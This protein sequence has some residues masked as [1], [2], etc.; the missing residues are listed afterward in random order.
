MQNS[1]T[2]EPR[3]HVEKRRDTFCGMNVSKRFGAPHK[4]ETDDIARM[5]A[6]NLRLIRKR[7]KKEARRR[8]FA[9]L[10]GLPEDLPVR[11]GRKR[12]GGRPSRKSMLKAEK[13]CGARSKEVKSFQRR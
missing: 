12:K 6:N 3:G 8:K 10:R 11:R 7:E 9:V 5:A 1:L 13:M 2:T 4:Y